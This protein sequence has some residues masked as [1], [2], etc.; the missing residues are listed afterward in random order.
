MA[1]IIKYAKLLMRKGLKADLTT[2]DEAELGLATDT[3][4]VFVGT[5]A[6]NVQLAKQSDVEDNQDKIGNLQ[7]NV[8][9]NTS[10]LLKTT[11]SSNV[12]WSVWN[13]L[14]QRGVNVKWFGVV[15]NKYL[16]DGTLNPNPTDDY[17]N[18]R[19]A[20]ESGLPL[21]FPP[22]T[23]CVIN[24][25][26]SAPATKNLKIIG[27]G[28]DNCSI[29]QK[30]KG[31]R[32][33]YISGKNTEISGISFYGTGV[34]FSGETGENGALLDV[35]GKG[36]N[37]SNCRFED[38]DYLSVLVKGTSGNVKI[39]NCEFNN[40]WAEEIAFWA[41]DGIIKGNTFNNG[42]NNAIVTRGSKDVLIEGNVF[43]N[44]GTDIDAVIDIRNNYDA[45][46]L[47][48][49]RITIQN[50]HFVDCYF[51][52]S[53]TS[54]TA[55]R[56][57]DIS[58]LTN[59]FANPVAPSYDNLIRLQ[60][61]KNVTFNDNKIYKGGVVHAVLIT[62][63]ENI[64]ACRNTIDTGAMGMNLNGDGLVVADNNIIRNLTGIGVIVRC[65]STTY[66][67]VSVCGNKFVSV[68]IGI[69]TDSIYIGRLMANN[70]MFRSTTTMG[71]KIKYALSLLNTVGNV[72]ADGTT[73]TVSTLVQP[74][75][76]VKGRNVN[77]DPEA[78]TT[79][80]RPS[81]PTIGQAYFD[82]TL[83]KPINCK[84]RAILDANGAVTTAAVWVDA[85][86]TAV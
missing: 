53:S 8:N 66:N 1:N 77:Y 60:Q 56:H 44:I 34:G 59:R 48:C 21:Y 29:T 46:P 33:L 71:I 6:G 45:T 31:L 83:N 75:T 19:K 40:A 72:F 13:E 50:N 54:E 14:E 81:N 82:T 18:L 76:W 41:S 68:D 5:G 73:K 85:T 4:E 55:A 63:S 2:L 22:N 3:K 27:S 12:S 65:P 42:D 51:P 24:T 78:G 52:I 47:A 26:L 64:E 9:T 70:N 16:S 79:G 15:G 35:I 30:T 25:A 80:V 69:Q 20:V 28:K 11:N 67:T 39:T 37:I 84:T 57:I 10:Q 36:I 86:G 38:A 32:L 49:E 43:K 23:H 17:A 74:T 62:E 61:C 7:T 58:V